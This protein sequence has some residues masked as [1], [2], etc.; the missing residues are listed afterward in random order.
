MANYSEEQRKDIL[1]RSEKA[2][3]YL[4]TLDLQPAAFVSM[5]NTKD[6]LFAVKVDAYLQDT[7]YTQQTINVSD[8]K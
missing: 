3:S 2:I 4:K 6:G 5:A 8:L 1:E 7:R